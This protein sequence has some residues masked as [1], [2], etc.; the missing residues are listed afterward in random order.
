MP[1]HSLEPPG[2]SQPNN[3]FTQAAEGRAGSRSESCGKGKAYEY[4]WGIYGHTGRS[5]INHLN[6]EFEK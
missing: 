2:H 3:V 1:W 4:I 5:R 6:S